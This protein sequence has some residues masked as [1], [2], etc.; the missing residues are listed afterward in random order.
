MSNEDGETADLASVR[1]TVKSLLNSCNGQYEALVSL[2]RDVLDGARQEVAAALEPSLNQRVH[3]QVQ[4]TCDEKRFVAHWVNT[5]LASLGLA[6]SDPLTGRPSRLVIVADV[7]GGRWRFAFRDKEG[8]RH[9]PG[10]RVK[11]GE[12]EVVLADTPSHSRQRSR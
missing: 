10:G 6:V 8:A 7:E 2:S 1:R 12:L 5:D 9:T 11:L 4:G 3:N